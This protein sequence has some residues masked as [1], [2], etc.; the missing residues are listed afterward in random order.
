MRFHGMVNHQPPTDAELV[1]RCRAGDQDAWRELVDR[2]SRYVYAIAVQAYRL[3]EADAEDVFQEVFTRVYERLGQLRD[4][5]AVRPWI[6][7][8]TRHCCVDRLRE[9]SR[10]ELIEELEAGDADD[11]LD[12]LEEAW[13]VREALAQ[14]SQPCQEVLDRFF[15]RDESYR[16]IGEA[17]AI[18]SGTIASR[19]SRCLAQL[20][21]RYGS[22]GRI[23]ARAPSGGRIR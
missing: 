1:A 17:L 23:P 7:Q 2:F 22:E 10:L 3:P 11:A 14:L 8:L 21:E 12:R 4:D 16:T 9:G 15:T 18:P 13:G 19:I 20:R 6:A 5:G